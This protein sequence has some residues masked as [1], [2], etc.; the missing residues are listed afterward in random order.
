MIKLKLLDVREMGQIEAVGC[1]ETTS[2][3]MVH[4]GPV[5]TMTT[6]K[7]HEN[8]RTYFVGGI[9][10]QCA[11]FPNQVAPYNQIVL[12]SQRLE[13]NAQ[14]EMHP[15]PQQVVAFPEDEVS[16]VHIDGRKP[17]EVSQASQRET[18]H[19]PEQETAPAHPTLQRWSFRHASDPSANHQYPEIRNEI[20]S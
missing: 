14:N 9:G 4:I 19:E 16:T 17:V 10:I 12:S 2:L 11:S 3:Y 5:F 8:Q 20:T 7:T 6:R 18:I 13:A 1:R 15:E